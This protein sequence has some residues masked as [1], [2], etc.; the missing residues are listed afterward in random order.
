LGWRSSPPTRPLKPRFQLP[1]RLL[2]FDWYRRKI[3]SLGLPLSDLKAD[4]GF[5]AY[6]GA[7]VS[8]GSLGH[9]RAEIGK[10]IAPR[11]ILIAENL[12]RISRQGPKIARQLIASIVDIGVDI[13]VASI[14]VKL[15]PGWENDPARSHLVDAELGRAWKE[16]VYKSDRGRQTWQNKK[17]NAGNGLAITRCAPAWLTVEKVGAKPVVV[18]KRAVSVRRIFPLAVLGLGCKRIVR[19]LVSEG[20]P[21]FDNG[22][23]RGKGWSPEYVQKILGSRAVL[24]ENQPHKLVDDKRVPVG[25]AI[26]NYYPAVVFFEEWNAARASVEAKNRNLRASGKPGTGGG[27]VRVNS[28][29]N[30]LVRDETNGG[31]VMVYHCKKGDKP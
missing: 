21:S 29:F 7:H 17:A 12:D 11:S 16:S 31:V 20:H 30:L 10:S 15:T 19:T 14:G 6:K 8:K 27:R 23:K 26:A 5:S 24:G 13:H 18:A 3:A 28:I 22:K 9:F 1:E 2:V 25:E 4:D